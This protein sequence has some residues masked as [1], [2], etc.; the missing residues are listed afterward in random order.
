MSRLIYAGLLRLKKSKLFWAVLAA[1]TVACV[2]ACVRF[3]RKSAPYYEWMLF[4]LT[5][6][7]CFVGAAFVGLFAGTEYAD[8]TMRNKLISGHTRAAIYGANLCVSA[9]ACAAFQGI[10]FVVIGTLGTLLIGTLGQPVQIA[11]YMLCAL[12]VSV[13]FAALFM[14]IVMIS[15]RKAG[16]IVAAFA[17]AFGLILISDGIWDR[18]LEP[19]TLQSGPIVVHEDGTISMEPDEI[20]ENPLYVP[21]GALRDALTVLNSSLP[22]GQMILL[23]NRISLIEPPQ[24]DIS[25]HWYWPLGS[26]LFTLMVS[27]A[28][29]MLF[30]RKDIK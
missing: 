4:E 13:S 17:I 11:F 1:I 24:L 5:S 7:L 8:G 16:A 12:L 29:F 9:I 15:G 25:G 30:N 19:Q 18:L 2:Y 27:A 28:G 20:T 3:S 26:M 10:V 14:A 23:A 6:V 21:E 22:T